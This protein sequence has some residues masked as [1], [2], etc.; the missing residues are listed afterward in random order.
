MIR[1]GPPYVGMF[2][3]FAWCEGFTQTSM[4]HSRSVLQRRYSGPRPGKQGGFIQALILGGLALLAAVVAFF[5]LSA[6]DSSSSTS[7]E[8]NKMRATGIVQQGVDLSAGVSRAILDGIPAASLV[9]HTSGT[10]GLL[11]AN[12]YVGGGAMPVPPAGSGDGTAIWGFDSGAVVTDSQAVP[13]DLGTSAKDTVLTL[14]GLTK[15]VCTRINNVLTGET[16]IKPTDAA[17]GGSYTA[18]TTLEGATVADAT[19]AIGNSQGCVT[20]A[21]GAYMYY[22]VVQIN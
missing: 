18:A 20:T 8:E 19:K 1:R 5:A 10:I 6:N 17:I 22:R 3:Y 7:K 2:V 15:D 12:G 4:M 11:A 13:K 16:I 14:P 21:A 9:G